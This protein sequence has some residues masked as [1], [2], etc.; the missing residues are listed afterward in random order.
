MFESRISAGTTEKLPG[1]EKSHAKTVAWKMRGKILRTKTNKLKK[2]LENCQNV[3]RKLPRSACMWPELADLT[4][5][6]P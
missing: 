5:H 6:G 1:W 3:A 2:R 4:F